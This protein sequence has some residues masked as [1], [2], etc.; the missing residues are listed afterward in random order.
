[1]ENTATR[2]CAIPLAPRSGGRTD[3]WGIHV[4]A[5]RHWTLPAGRWQ[6]SRAKGQR[7]V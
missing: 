3:V 4:A 5:P 6:A 1:L 7:K 2:Y